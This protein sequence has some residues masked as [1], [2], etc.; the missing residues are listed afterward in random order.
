M[1]ENIGWSSFI[2]YP[3]LLDRHCEK[4]Y[5]LCCCRH[6]AETLYSLPMFP[7]KSLDMLAA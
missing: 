3:D 4:G 2:S 6:I 1:W 5:C 7:A